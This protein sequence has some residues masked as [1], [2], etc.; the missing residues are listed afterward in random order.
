MIKNSTSVQ[1][2]NDH[3][4]IPENSLTENVSEEILLF[5]PGSALFSQDIIHSRSK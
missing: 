4:N 5:L 1:M 3:L 2:F